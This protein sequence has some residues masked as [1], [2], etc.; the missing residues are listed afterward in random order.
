MNQSNHVIC[1]NS[2][3][4]CPYSVKNMQI[5]EAFEVNESKY[6]IC[7][8]SNSSSLKSWSDFCLDDN[9]DGFPEQCF[10]SDHK[11]TFWLGIWCIINSI[12]GIIG[13]LLTIFAIP[14]ASIQNK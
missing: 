12:I 8:N 1:D 9:S 14:Y 3:S 11:M 13:N 10:S 2:T 4:N 5:L 7:D 6:L